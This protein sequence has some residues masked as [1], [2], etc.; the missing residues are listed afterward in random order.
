MDQLISARGTAGHALLIDCRS[1][2]AQPVPLPQLMLGDAVV[3]FSR[4]DVLML[5]DQIATAGH[6][7]S[8]IYGALPP[9]VRRR[10][11]ERFAEGES[12]ILVATDAIG[13]GL[14]LDVDHVAFAADRKLLIRQLMDA[15]G[16]SSM[17]QE[18]MS[19]GKE[20]AEAQATATT[21]S[22]E[23]LKNRARINEAPPPP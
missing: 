19:G 18:Q 20:Q 2:Q 8:V 15:Q 21:H 22:A 17:L 12:H 14:N 4:R 7:V 23:R 6:P 16:L 10:E 1:L 3:A 13:M 11:A 5:R 9:E